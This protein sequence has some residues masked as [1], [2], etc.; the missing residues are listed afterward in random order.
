M[1]CA[2]MI[3]FS[4]LQYQLY[5]IIM[6]NTVSKSNSKISSTSSNSSN[7]IKEKVEQ[8]DTN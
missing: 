5:Y 3:P 1:H 6:N 7:N 8:K 2:R 4:I